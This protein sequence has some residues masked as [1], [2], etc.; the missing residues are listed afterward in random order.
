MTIVKCEYKSCLYNENG[1]CNKDILNI[2]IDNDCADYD[3][4]EEE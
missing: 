2:Y 1:E 3:F 4:K